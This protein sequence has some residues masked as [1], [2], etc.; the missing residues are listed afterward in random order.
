MS[1][2]KLPTANLAE[3]YEILMDKKFIEQPFEV[4]SA[5]M[6][7]KFDKTELLNGENLNN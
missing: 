5:Q 7:K 2:N 1:A 6:Q 3:L 4:C